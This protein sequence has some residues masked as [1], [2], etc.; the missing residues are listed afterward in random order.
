ML[1]NLSIF[2]E[3]FY[4]FYL[5]TEFYEGGDLVS[6]IYGNSPIIIQKYAPM[7]TNQICEGINYLHSLGIMHRDIKPENFCV[8]LDKTVKI[9]DFGFSTVLGENEL[10]SEPYCT[11]Q[12]S[13]PEI[14]ISKPYNKSIDIWSLGTT[15]YSIFFYRTP[16]K[17]KENSVNIDNI[18]KQKYE[19]PKNKIMSPKIKDAVENL[20]NKCLIVDPCKRANIKDIVKLN[21]V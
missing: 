21:L 18:L 15:I 14:L 7:F 11:L 5:I 12:F 9:V 20:I 16:F 10:T 13:A 3:D 19:L 17:D 2:F 4:Y 8:S 6:F 1:W